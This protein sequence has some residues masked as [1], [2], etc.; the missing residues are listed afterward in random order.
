MNEAEPGLFLPKLAATLFVAAL[1]A[2]IHCYQWLALYS[3]QTLT[4]EKQGNLP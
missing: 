4:T 1:V 2:D 3:K